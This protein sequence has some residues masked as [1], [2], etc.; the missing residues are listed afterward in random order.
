MIHSDNDEFPR[1][2]LTTFG[3]RDVFERLKQV[4]AARLLFLWTS[5]VYLSDMIFVL[6]Q[7]WTKARIATAVHHGEH[8]THHLHV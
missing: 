6:L 4:L 2:N 1:L 3:T 7:A 8:D 5:P